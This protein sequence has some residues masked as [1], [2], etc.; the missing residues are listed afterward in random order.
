M[1]ELP[2]ITVC[3]PTYKRPAMLIRCLDAL[4]KL[5]HEGFTYSIVV[6][7]NDAGESA[8][9][10]VQE[11][12]KRHH[13]E[14]RY[15]VEPEQ[16]ISRARNK[17][18]ANSTGEFIAFIDDDEFPEPT[19]LGDLFV[20]CKKFS[21]DGVLGPVIPSFEGTPP[22]WL[23]K[24]GL[25][26]RP[27]FKTG[28][29][30]DNS[31]YMRTGNVFLRRRILDDLDTPFDPRMGRTGGEDADFFDRMLQAGRSFVWC[32]EA[33]VYEE[34]P[35]ERQKID[36]HV[37][38]AFIRGVTS[39]DQEPFIGLGTM[40]SIVAVMMY[41]VSLPFLLAAGRHLFVKYFIKDCDH[42]AKLFAHCG[43]KLVRER[44]F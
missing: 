40:K 34:V 4:A 43:V 14:I 16:N 44:M 15:E 9:N 19:W 18:V 32:N 42:L 24:S 6:A 38:R 23:L 11:W 39:A 8:K 22:E 27:S 36:Y 21:V 41:T 3:I 33:R 30:L 26:D 12:Q 17:A 13:I 31:K 10:V 29:G 2:H 35:R 20:A 25:C 1:P 7:D 28:T 5:Q 37:K